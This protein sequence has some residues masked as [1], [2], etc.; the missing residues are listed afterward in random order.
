MVL[1]HSWGWFFLDWWPLIFSLE[2]WDH[3]LVWVYGSPAVCHWR[4]PIVFRI[5]GH[6]RRPTV[7]VVFTPTHPLLQAARPQGIARYLAQI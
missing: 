7:P 3:F 2:W 5:L 1:D 4:E 6:N